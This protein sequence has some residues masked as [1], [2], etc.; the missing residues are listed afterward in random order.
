VRTGFGSFERLGEDKS[1][2]LTFVSI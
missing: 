1:D 2:Y